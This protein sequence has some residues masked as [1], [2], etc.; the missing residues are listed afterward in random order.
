MNHGIG[1]NI[2]T[3]IREGGGVRWPF[4]KP[5]FGERCGLLVLNLIQVIGFFYVTFFI[6]SS[7]K[8]V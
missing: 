5:L 1:E 6:A 4:F 7:L 3:F 2:C 8:R